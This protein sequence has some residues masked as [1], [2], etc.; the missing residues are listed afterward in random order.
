MVR[1]TDADQRTAGKLPVD[2]LW[3]G[4]FLQGEQDLYVILCQQVFQGG[5][6]QQ[7][8]NR[9][10]PGLFLSQ[11]RQYWAQEPQLY[12]ISAADAETLRKGFLTFL[13]PCSGETGEFQDLIGVLGEQMACLG[14]ANALAGPEKQLR[15]Q[16]VLQGTDLVADGRLRDAQ[17]FGG[18]G[19]IQKVGNCQKA[20]QLCGVHSDP[21]HGCR[22]VI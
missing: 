15:S 16:F 13:Q 19:K 9:Q 4:G 14:Q 21:S 2:R 5:V 22:Q 6:R 10:Q 18:A 8:Q 12:E 17:L 20:L 1:G 3:R 11:L 7:P